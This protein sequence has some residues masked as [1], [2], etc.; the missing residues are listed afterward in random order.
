MFIECL[1]SLMGGVEM[2]PLTRLS[3]IAL[4]VSNWFSFH[5]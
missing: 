4:G 1:V 5:V 3:E 2:V